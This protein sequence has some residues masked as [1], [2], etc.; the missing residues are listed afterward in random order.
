ML[1]SQGVSETSSPCLAEFDKIAISCLYLA[2]KHPLPEN[3]ISNLCAFFPVTNAPG[4]V[5]GF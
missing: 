4:R 3:N 1:L 2:G 5:Q